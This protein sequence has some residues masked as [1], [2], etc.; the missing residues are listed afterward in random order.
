MNK[1]QVLSWY[2]YI[3]SGMYISSEQHIQPYK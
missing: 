2:S 1:K 3:D